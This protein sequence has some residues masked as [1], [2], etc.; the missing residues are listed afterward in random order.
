MKNLNRNYLVLLLLAT[1][2]ACPGIAAY[3]LYN[4]PHW[5]AAAP[6]NKGQLLSPPLL[7]TNIKE[8]AKWR[9]I[10]WNPGDC[11]LVC[12]QQIDK[13]GRI[14]LALGRRLYEVDELLLITPKTPAL[15][16]SLLASL[17]DQDV[18][19]VVV[20][21]VAHQPLLPSH[22]Q[23]YIGNSTNYLVLAYELNA[24]P[25]DIFHDL[26]QLLSSTA[27]KKG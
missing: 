3:M 7:I 13:L 18:K 5:L 10:V 26:Q 17:N 24:K 12:R 20:D 15:S 27:K 14:R 6:T 4:H 23:L 9:L 2:F 8:P 25:A 11:D 16:T 21:P 1:I 19:L 22:P